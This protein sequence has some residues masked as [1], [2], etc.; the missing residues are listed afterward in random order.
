MRVSK[1]G[2]SLAMR[3]P[4]TLVDALG[5][6]ARDRSEVVPAD[7]ARLVVAKAEGKLQAVKRMRARGL[8]IPDE[9]AFDRDEANAR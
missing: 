4:K 6:K 7:P 8:P 1:R 5:L 9:Y 3:R 2:N